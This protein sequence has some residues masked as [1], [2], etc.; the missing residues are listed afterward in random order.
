MVL[1]FYVRKIARCARS[2]VA[3]E[4]IAARNSVELGAWHQHHLREIIFGRLYGSR[5][6]EEGPL[7]LP[8]P[9]NVKE[10]NVGLEKVFPKNNLGEIEAEK[11]EPIADHQCQWGRNC[12]RFQQTGK[13]WAECSSCRKSLSDGDI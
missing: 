5:I 9:F 3:S 13:A 11:I 7:P 2:T 8:N 4:A 1:G 6:R 10:W 12:D